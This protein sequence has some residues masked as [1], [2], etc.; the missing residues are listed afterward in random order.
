MA[1]YDWHN[2]LVFAEAAH[3]IGNET[4]FRNAVS[5]SYYAAYW[6]AR[7]I[8]ETGNV[9]IPRMKSHEFVY[10]SY[11]STVNEDN[12][13]LGELLK[14]LR[15]G[16]TWA[17]YED[18]P[19]ITQKHAEAAIKDAKDLIAYFNALTHADKSKACQAATAIYADYVNP[20]RI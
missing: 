1:V 12:E 19:E 15:D 16:R 6:R 13:I 4:G 14:T 2:Y 5:R 17:D 18:A 10:K 11:I 20:P 9:S 8:L 3:N 7:R